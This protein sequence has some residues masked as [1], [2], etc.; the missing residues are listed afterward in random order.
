MIVFFVC[1]VC[2][3]LADVGNNIVG[4]PTLELSGFRF[5]ASEDECIQAGFVDDC[6]F[7]FAT[8]GAG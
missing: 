6:Y 5:A 2:A 1:H 3:V 7:L 4:D 8:K